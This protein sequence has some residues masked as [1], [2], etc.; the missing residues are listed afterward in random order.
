MHWRF[1][2][3][4][5]HPGSY[6]MEF[7]EHLVHS[8]AD[9]SG[10]PTV[11]FY[12]WQPPAISLGWNQRA[13]DIDTESAR[14]DGIDVVRRPTGG[15]AILHSEELT[16]SVVMESHAKNILAT[17]N[18]ISQ[19]L[20]LGLKNLGAAV[21]LEKSQPH[22]PSLYHSPSSAMCYSSSA[23]YEIQINGKKLVG[24][25]QRRYVGHDSE[26]LVL[27]HGSLLLG[28]DHLRIVDYLTLDNGEDKERLR[29]EI[30][31]RTIDLSM[32][33]GRTVS[34]AECAEAVRTGF[35][36]AWGIRF[37]SPNLEPA[38]T[39]AVL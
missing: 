26:D 2:D 9:G 35:E 27:Q 21:S 37:E 15:R 33:L 28:S 12:G 3:T 30:K 19:A 29:Q 23:R 10:I 18:E 38:T 13:E 34:F 4:G 20:V 36:E 22:F 31:E 25:A 6:N 5:K 7:D 14:R 11:R 8:L 17:Y 32:A 16:Y 1:L 39:G 24:S